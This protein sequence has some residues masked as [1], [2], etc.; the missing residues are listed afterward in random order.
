LKPTASAP[1]QAGSLYRVHDRSTHLGLGASLARHG[2]RLSLGA[3][4][5]WHR[6]KLSRQA[7]PSEAAL[8]SRP[9]A[10]LA[11]AW[12][13]MESKEPFALGSWRW[14]PYAQAAWLRLRR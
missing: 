9:A 7:D 13:H 3:A 10:R 2:W 12:A 14:M 6:A 8:H 5:S 4:H 1:A 11:Q